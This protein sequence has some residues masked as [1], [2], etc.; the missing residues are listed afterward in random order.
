MDA[1]LFTKLV[2][3]AKVG[4]QLPDAIYLHKDAFETLPNT[5]IK[6][7]PAV[8]NALNVK[9][10][11]WNLVKLFKKDF[12][13]SLLHY[14]TFYSD[15][16]PA[17]QKSINVDLSKL[18]HRITDYAN[19]DNPPILHRKE[20]M[21]LSKNPHYEHF[22][23]ITAEGENAGL[24]DNTRL[25]GFKQSW[26]NLIKRHGYELVDGRLFRCS[27][28]PAITH[29]KSI[30]RHKTAIVRHDL[31]APLKSLAKS[32]F[33]EGDHSIFDYGCG[34]GDDLRELEAHG[35]DVIGWDPNFQPDNDKVASDIVNLGFVLNVIEDQDERLEVLL[36]AWELAD[37]LLVVSVMLA[38]ESFINQFT[39]YKDGVIT[40]RNTFQKY[41]AQN[42]IKNYIYP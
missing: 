36:G 4:K 9:E 13:L 24:Y 12:R 5:L 38:N 39:P 2:K 33:L 25:I 18:S 30:D 15:S 31:S 28:L 14:P 32:S 11:D 23:Q 27:S 29:E 20:T 19:A 41:Y 26:L 35:L 3:E 37:K 22:T 21:V 40:S 6:F 8:A 42:E 17:L 7:I 16:Y 34:R 10:N 1:Q